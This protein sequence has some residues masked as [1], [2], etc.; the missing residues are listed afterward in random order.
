[1]HALAHITGGGLVENVPRVLPAGCGVEIDRCAWEVP[2]LFRLIEKLGRVPAAEMARVF[3]LGIGMVVL[4]PEDAGAALAAR[5]P[6]A[7]R[8]GRVVAG[9]RKVDLR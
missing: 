9:E 5:C 7:R 3:N 8:L 6:D 2:P 4:L 1:V